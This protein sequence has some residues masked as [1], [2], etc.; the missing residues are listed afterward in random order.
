MKISEENFC[1]AFSKKK[2]E[3][4]KQQITQIELKKASASFLNEKTIDL[5]GKIVNHYCD[6][7]IQ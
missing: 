1:E 6:N 4:K 7:K 5:S 2:S 3:S